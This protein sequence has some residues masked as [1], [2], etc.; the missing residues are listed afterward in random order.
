M[1][2]SL[3]QPPPPPLQ[4]KLLQL[5]HPNSPACI[6]GRFTILPSF[7]TGPHCWSSKV[8]GLH[9]CA[10]VPRRSTAYP[11]QRR[12]CGWRGLWDLA[13][14]VDRS[15][16]SAGQILGIRAFLDPRRSDNNPPFAFRDRHLHNLK[17]WATPCMSR[18]AAVRQKVIF[19]FFW[20]LTYL[21]QCKAID[22]V[23]DFLFILA[24]Q[25]ATVLI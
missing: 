22:E 5:S 24:V 14:T 23:A 12:Q 10:R 7:G 13:T 3:L 1:S 15:R 9:D 20:L 16:L 17:P 8:P 4:S 6:D 25:M 18:I 19:T 11:Q 21:S 2:L